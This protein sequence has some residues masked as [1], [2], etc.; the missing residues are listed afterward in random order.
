MGLEARHARTRALKAR[1]LADSARLAQARVNS[2]LR[3]MEPAQQEQLLHA[4]HRLVA[5]PG[6]GSAYKAFALAHFGADAAGNLDVAGFA[7][8]N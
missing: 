5:S 3:T 8:N 7:A 4:V 6:M 1:P 2:L